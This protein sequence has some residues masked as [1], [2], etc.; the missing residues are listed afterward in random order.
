M[1][2]RRSHPDV[3]TSVPSS[4]PA[5]GKVASLGTHEPVAFGMFAG[6]E[7]PDLVSGQCAESAAA[8]SHTNGEPF[9]AA[10]QPSE[11]ENG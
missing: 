2:N 5:Y 7:P 1:A 9:R 8:V 10:L 6:S 3:V 4:G 11:M